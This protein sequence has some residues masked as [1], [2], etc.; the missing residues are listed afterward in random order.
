MRRLCKQIAE[1]HFSE[2]QRRTLLA[3]ARYAIYEVVLRGRLPDLPEVSGIL[4]EPGAA[5]VSLFHKRRLRGCM[6]HTYRDVPLADTVVQCAITAALHDPRFRPL[7]ADELAGLKI[8]ISV[9]SEFEPVLPESIKVGVHGILATREESRGLLLPQVAVERGW[10]SERFLEE[11]CRKAGFAAN[12]W[13]NPE[14][15]IFGFTAEMFSETD[16]AGTIDQPIP[17]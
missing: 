3:R 4:A 8:E 14:T 15:R 1:Q 16:L 17:V 12:S 2:E 13:R 7:C 5:F 6:G 9:L 11:T 10:S